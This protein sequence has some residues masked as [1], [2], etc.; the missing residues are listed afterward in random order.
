MNI[1]HFEGITTANQESEN[2]LRE[3]LASLDD[4]R[5]FKLEAG[6]G[7]GKT[8]S[9]IDALRHI[10]DD[11]AKYLPREGQQVACVTYTNVARNEIIRRTDASVHVFAGT[12]HGFLW[13]IISRFQKILA[14]EVKTLPGWDGILADAGPVD[15]FSISYDLGFRRVRDGVI[16]IHHDDVP[17]LAIRL[18]GRK[19]FRSLVADRF[20]I[21][22]IDEYQDTPA[23]LA[24]AMIGNIADSSSESTYGFFGDHWQQIYDRTCGRIDHLP[25]TAIDK[26]AN[27]RSSPAVVDFLNRMRPELPQAPVPGRKTGSVVI[28]HTNSWAG[29]RESRSKKG[30]ISDGALKETLRCVAED[31]LLR[32]QVP[33]N[34]PFKTLML[35]HSSIAGELGFGKINEAFRYNDD[36]V[37]KQDEV[38]AFLL[39]TLEP[40]YEYFRNR[41][42]GLMFDILKRSR[43][44]MRLRSDK[45]G[46]TD[47]FHRLDETRASGTV[48]DVLDLVLNQSYFSPP[49]AV[50]DRQQK[51]A[52]A[53]S[54]LE[55]DQTL[56]E[57]RQI[58]EYGKLREVQYR[59]VVALRAYVDEK[60]PF[61]TQHGVKGEE[62]PSVLAVFGGWSLYNFPKM[63][64]DFPRRHSLD[65]DDRKRF[66]RSRNLFYV[67]CSRA[68]ENLALLF[69][70]ELSEE[71]LATMEEWIGPLNIVTVEYSPDGT[72]RINHPG[73][74][75]SESG[76]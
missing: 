29:P 36:Y 24:E 18:F 55:S 15:G 74:V 33:Q 30:Q 65:E 71:A 70:T 35:T 3:I 10:L 7:A 66:E 50:H 42:Y 19:K 34:R 20:P 51:W 63:L 21:I 44:R 32:N 47:L 12:I 72:P 22:F 14:Q 73:N 62:Y 58:V 31:A 43:P 1:A 23:G 25:V 13:E 37:R 41:Q 68:Q 27:W 9:L 53:L 76:C 49:R 11:R 4:R 6:A 64:A 16:R 2:S 48:G 28:Y 38:V 5:N 75:S 52:A 26:R 56:S 17:A 40:A 59:Q 69:T 39:E 46:W 45:T 8:H 61:S 67:A 57:P 60:T 54:V